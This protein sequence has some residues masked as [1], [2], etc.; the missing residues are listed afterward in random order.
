VILLSA[1]LIL[2]WVYD[3]IVGI[4]NMRLG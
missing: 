3:K 2:Y 1:I 4:D